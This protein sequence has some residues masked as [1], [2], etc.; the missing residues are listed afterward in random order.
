[1]VFHLLVQDIMDS[2]LCH[3]DANAY[4]NGFRTDTNMSPSFLVGGG[5]GDIKTR[6]TC[7]YNTKGEYKF[8]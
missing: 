8:H 6:R 1:M 3:A 7:P 4:T 5:G 2:R